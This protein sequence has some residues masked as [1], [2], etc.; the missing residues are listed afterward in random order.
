MPYASLAIALCASLATACLDAELD[1]ETGGQAVVNGTPVI[2]YP[3]AGALMRGTS[4]EDSFMQCSGTLIGCDTFL[5][6]AH[7]VCEDIETCN[8]QIP[9]AE[10]R[11]FFQHAGVYQASRIEVMQGYTFPNFGDAAI[12]HLAEPVVGIDPTPL[13]PSNPSLTAEMTIV[14]FGLTQKDQSDSG[15]K[16]EG[17]LRRT[18]CSGFDDDLMLCFDFGDSPSVS[19]SGDSGGPNFID[20]NGQLHVA[21]IVSGGGSADSC[22]DRQK[23]ATNVS[24]YLGFISP[25]ADAIGGSCGATPSVTDASTSV[26]TTAGP[27][28]E[29]DRFT[30]DVPPGTALL[31]LSANAII[32][33]SLLVAARKGEEA[34]PIVNDCG[35]SGRMAAFCE[36]N[37]PAAGE[38]HILMQ[39]GAEYQ[40][41]VTAIAGAPIAN[42]ESYLASSGEVL[43][44]EVSDGL[45]AN[46]E[47][48]AGGSLTAEVTSQPANGVVVISGDG[49]FQY[50]SADGFIGTDSFTYRAVEGEYSGE[51]E[52]IVTVEEG[53]GC[54]CQSGGNQS[55]SAILLLLACAFAW[56]RRRAL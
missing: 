42:P 3:S 37:S 7:C 29:Q 36:V 26:T 23:F 12:V 41:A 19:C 31:R 43:T 18:P 45:L 44:V 9:P 17:V 39:S 53:G 55:G 15:I 2:D 8:T 51:T 35:G 30:V 52:V 20:I 6:A 14:G 50:Q 38:W 24:G 34:D 28:G 46:D 5:T 21:G 16:R 27:G 48:G 47:P 22:S 33:G 11:V 40:G 10:L 49:S 54:G 1:T 56:R 13:A 32:N 4:L 25:A